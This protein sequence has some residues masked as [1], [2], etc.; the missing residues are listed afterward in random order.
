MVLHRNDP[1]CLRGIPK[2]RFVKHPLLE[3]RDRAN[4]LEREIINTKIGD[5]EAL[6]ANVLTLTMLVRGLIAVAMAEVEESRV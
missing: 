3:I 4:A 1:D 6:L 2:E 5:T